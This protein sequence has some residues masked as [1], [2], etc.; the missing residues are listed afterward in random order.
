MYWL[1]QELNP[2]IKKLF[3]VPLKFNN[4][5]EYEESYTDNQNGQQILKDKNTIVESS[6]NFCTT[7]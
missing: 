4:I 3:N 7:I 1:L 6:Y 2:H 5:I